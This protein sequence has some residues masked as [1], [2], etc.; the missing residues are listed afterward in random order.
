MGCPAKQS[1]Y[2]PFSSQI[3]SS[4]FPLWVLLPSLSPSSCCPGKISTPSCELGP[5][6][7]T[8][9]MADEAQTCLTSEHQPHLFM[10]LEGYH[11]D[12]QISVLHFLFCLWIYP[13]PF[14]GNSW[15]RYSSLNSFFP[16]LFKN[17]NI[18]DLQCCVSFRYIA[19]WFSYPYICIYSYPDSF[20]YSYY[21]MILSIV[22]YAI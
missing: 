3:P 21:Y 15:L 6:S 19:K 14:L 7:L 4:W 1:M 20:H 16:P 10:S 22:P 17:W 5:D 13:I 12:I 11:L 8:P 2:L 9:M 18:V